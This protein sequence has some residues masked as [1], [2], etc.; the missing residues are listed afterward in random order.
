MTESLSQAELRRMANSGSMPLTV[1]QGMALFDA[2]AATEEALLV[3]LAVKPGVKAGLS[4]HPLLRGLLRAP[5]RSAAASAVSTAT[6][7]ERLRGL[8]ADDQETVLRELVVDCSAAVLGHAEAGDIN[9]ER[10]FLESGFD[11]LM[12]VEL[13]NRLADTVGLRL[14]STVVFD[15]KTPAA[16]AR[17]LRAR[18]ADQVDQSAA[19]TSEPSADTIGELYFGAVAEGKLDEGWTLL[20][21]VAA[22]RP[23]F[24][25]PD[26]LAEMPA[27]VTLAHGPVG[28]QLI[29]VS[30]PPIMG[31]VH[32]YARIAAHFRGDRTV[33]ALPLPGYLAGESLPRS[34]EAITLVIADSARRAADGAPFVLVGHSSA[35]PLALAAA[36]LLETRWG[37]RAD[38]VIL[39]DS[40]SLRHDPS[41][42]VDYQKLTVHLER[43]NDAPV[44][45][46]DRNRLSAMAH[47]L[48]HLPSLEFPPTTAPTLLVR[49]SVPLVGEKDVSVVHAQQ[50]LLIPADTIR[51]IDAD[52]L[53]LAQRDS[54][55]TAA[56]MK[57]WLATLC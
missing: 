30:S 20:T 32:Q 7:R 15:H 3:P 52:H 18:L 34:A 28:P 47:Y 45:S 43:Y 25:T 53:S 13:R 26:E 49:C 17:W 24:D 46:V 33:Q 37:V 56:V 8:S 31:G 19:T 21:A 29:C 27:P 48:N 50:E 51:T 39:L 16:L 23:R 55:A 9:P 2:A 41:E 44:V 14:P 57:E 12:S 36:G 54:G 11:S 22:M 6:L 1:E 10:D 38:G 42:N 5:R 35:G 40:L 4:T